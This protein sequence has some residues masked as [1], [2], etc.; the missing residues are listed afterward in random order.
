MK[1]LLLRLSAV[2]SDAEAA[3]RVIAYF[4]ELVA[5]HATI[6]DLV[7]ATAS[8]ANASPASNAAP[9]RLCACAPRAPARPDRSR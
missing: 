8:L 5:H 4:D 3:V 6:A 9:N 7:R 2:D 1:G